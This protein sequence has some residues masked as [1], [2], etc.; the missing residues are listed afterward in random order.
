MTGSRYTVLRHG[1][2]SLRVAST[3]GVSHSKGVSFSRSNRHLHA[4]TPQ[5][6]LGFPLSPHRSHSTGTP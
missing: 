4:D 5:W 6:P 1:H 3:P 2:S